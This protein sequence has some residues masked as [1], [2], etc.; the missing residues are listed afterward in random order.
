MSTQ[1]PQLKPEIIP[2]NVLAIYSPMAMLAGMQLDVF[3]PLAGGSMSASELAAALGLPRDKLEILLYSLVRAELLTVA[4]SRF[5]NTPEANA[6]LVRGVPGYLGSNHE[7]YSDL[8]ANLLKLGASI[9]AG[10]P[11]GKHDFARMSDAELGGF[12]RGLHAGALASGTQLVQMF[13]LDRIRTLVDVGGGSGG[14]AI[15]ACQANPQLSATV[16]ELPRVISFAQ[17]RIAEAKLSD[18]I[19]TQP[20]D[21]T[22]Q[23]IAGFFDAAVLRFF[24]QVLSR[25]A[26]KR[27]LKAVA[28]ALHPG[29]RLIIIGHILDNTRLYPPNTLGQSLVMLTIYDEGQAFTEAEYRAWLAEAGFED[30]AIQYEIATGGS[31]IMTAR[32]KQTAGA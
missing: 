18:R 24:I 2:R 22:S 6:F 10:S 9:R 26:A 1:D 29:G 15:A 19:A 30:V 27:A 16:A 12:L 13:G 25:D 20:V 11:L 5:A 23:P 3:T 32:K 21:A 4:D 7:L 17:E 31:S 8:W 28:N 14:V